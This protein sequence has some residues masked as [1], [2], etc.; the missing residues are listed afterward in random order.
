MYRFT[1]RDV[2]RLGWRGKAGLLRNLDRW[3]TKCAPDSIEDIQAIWMENPFQ[4][5][6]GT[7]YCRAGRGRLT[8]LDP[9]VTIDIP[10]RDPDDPE[11]DDPNQELLLALRDAAIRVIGVSYAAGSNTLYVITAGSRAKKV[12]KTIERIWA[13]R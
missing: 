4:N 8:R 12:R 13:D 2:Q 3:L 6:V 9:I 5:Y 7:I 10:W 11:K 1:H